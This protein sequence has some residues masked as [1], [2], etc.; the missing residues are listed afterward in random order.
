MEVGGGGRISTY[1]YTDTTRMTP[2]FRWAAMGAIL[3]FH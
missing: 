3:M 1:R 2:A